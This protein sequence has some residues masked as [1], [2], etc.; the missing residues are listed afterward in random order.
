[1]V[2]YKQTPRRSEGGKAPRKHLATKAARK[3]APGTRKPHRFRPGT[4]AL[5]EIRRYQGTTGNLIRRAPFGR[6]VRELAQNFARPGE[7]LRFQAT[8]ILALQE[9]AE[10]YLVGLF[11]ARHTCT[12]TRLRLR[13]AGVCGMSR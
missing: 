11:E 2:R 9:A 10:A 5:K 13:S 3:S 7:P 8:A 1:M 12:H 6:L 4:V